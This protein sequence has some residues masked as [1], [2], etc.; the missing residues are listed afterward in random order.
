MI[1]RKL[2]VVIQ[3]DNL[4]ILS[5]SPKIQG[6]I[7]TGPEITLVC[8][9]LEFQDPNHSELIFFLNDKS[10]C[11]PLYDRVISCF[12]FPEISKETVL[13]LEWLDYSLS[14]EESIST[15]IE[16]VTDQHQ[17]NK[18]YIETQEKYD[19][20][21][22]FIFLLKNLRPNGHFHD[23]IEYFPFSKKVLAF[24]FRISQLNNEKLKEAKLSIL[25]IKKFME[26]ILNDLFNATLFGPFTS[27]L[28]YWN[29]IICNASFER[30]QYKIDMKFFSFIFYDEIDLNKGFLLHQLNLDFI[31][32]MNEFGFPEV[33][34][35]SYI[36]IYDN[37]LNCIF[38]S[39]FY[40][41]K[42]NECIKNHTQLHQLIIDKLNSYK[43]FD[44]DFQTI[45]N[46]CSYFASFCLLYKN[47]IDFSSLNYDLIQDKKIKEIFM[48]L[49]SHKE[50]MQ[51]QSLFWIDD[52][53]DQYDQIYNENQG[54]PCIS[55]TVQLLPQ[56]TFYMPKQYKPP[57]T[58]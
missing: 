46:M 28:F 7:V 9:N 6:K 54:F 31:K 26:V 42:L 11:I 41:K 58:F 3:N 56:Q 27:L 4:K 23:L 47:Y 1:R 10:F 19:I 2:F 38:E 37:Q 48:S 14:E 35:L 52:E 25:F 44:S 15:L 21:S 16:F 49:F 32:T 33:L 24:L 36:N 40:Q 53:N 5:S 57:T 29:Y 34:L 51:H 17:L 30:E 50:I 13:S 18:F 20:L 12:C 45:Q 22:S 8:Y 55:N 43:N 39:Q